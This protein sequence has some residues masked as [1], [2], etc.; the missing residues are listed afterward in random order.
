MAEDSPDKES[1]TEE[2]SAHK[3]SKAIEQGNIPFS[4][5]TV[6]FGTVSSF[7]I[8]FAFIIAPAFE[9]LI[10]ILHRY[11]EYA[12]QIDIYAA[13]NIKYLFTELLTLIFIAIAPIFIVIA[14]GGVGAS[15][16][17][18]APQFILER[19][20]P[21]A[22]RISPKE[23]FK[24]IFSKTGLVE[25][26]K[27]LIKFFIINLILY[28]TF[29]HNTLVFINA[30]LFDPI[31]IAYFIKQQIS[32][33]LLSTLVALG[34]IAT[35]DIFWTRLKWRQELRMTKQEVKDEYKE[36]E[37]NPAVKARMRSLGRAR[38]RARMLANVPQSTVVITNPTH[39]AIALRYKAKQDVA[40]VVIAKGQDFLA[41]RIREIAT[42]HNIHIIEN[43]ELARAL[44]KQVEVNQV[45]P[46]DFY[47]AVAEIIRY[48]NKIG[49]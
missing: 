16:L 11:F 10:T 31:N 34:A 12:G 20:R 32:R 19:I 42:A 25:F 8:I 35:F 38:A 47:H 13:Q 1:K 26:A 46:E 30:F 37:G 6:L 45:I 15:I 43:V 18:N 22:A 2:P 17:Q 40:P 39:F 27:V 29:F 28:L 33:L 3:I 5:E 7:A 24:R 4:K 14:L 21:K 49:K 36:M 44:Y 41:L 9:K 23:G 48:I